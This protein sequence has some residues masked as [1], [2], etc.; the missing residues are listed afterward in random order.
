M[1]IMEPQLRPQEEKFMLVNTLSGLFPPLSIATI[2]IQDD[3]G[4]AMYPSSD[5]CCFQFSCGFHNGSSDNCFPTGSL[6]TYPWDRSLRSSTRH[7]IGVQSAN[8]G[9]S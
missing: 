4:R 3:H 9:G 8:L 1:S 2:I 7:I 6:G 5:F